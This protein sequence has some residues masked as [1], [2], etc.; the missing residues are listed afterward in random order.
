MFLKIQMQNL[1]AERGFLSEFFCIQ[2]NHSSN[3]CFQS[4][5]GVYG[6]MYQH[7][8]GYPSYGPYPSP[9]SPVPTMGHDGQLYGPPHYQYTAQYYQPPTPPPTTGAPNKPATSQGGVSTTVATEK[10]A[11]TVDTSKGNSNGIANGKSN[12]HISSGQPRPNHQNSSLPS[13]GSYGRGILPGGLPSGYQDPRFGFDGMRSPI[14][15]YDCPA[16]T[17]G[18]Q[19][20]PTTSSAPSAV[21]HV[22]NNPS[23]R[24]Q[25][26]HPLPHLMVGISTPLTYFYNKRIVCLLKMVFFGCCVS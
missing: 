10:P 17:D 1:D 6:D 26:L 18:Q 19:R 13:N 7:G 3:V 4:C 22:A 2:M 20:T 16:F 12:G 8:Y 9:G 14:P 11:A 5:Q 25:I 23:G 15:W 24:N 21:S